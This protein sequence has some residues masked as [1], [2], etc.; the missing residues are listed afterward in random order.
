MYCQ[1]YHEDGPG[2]LS[3]LLPLRRTEPLFFRSVFTLV[4]VSLHYVS[5]NVLNSALRKY[6][7]PRN[8]SVIPAVN[9]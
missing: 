1:K 5:I 3:L 8:R 7:K 9:L 6:K 2:R 4:S